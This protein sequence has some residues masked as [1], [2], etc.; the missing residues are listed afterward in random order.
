MK[1]VKKINK[2]RSFLAELK[3]QKFELGLGEPAK[4]RLSGARMGRDWIV[5]SPNCIVAGTNGR[6]GSANGAS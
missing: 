6:I 3:S 1:T 2:P 4:L 5:W